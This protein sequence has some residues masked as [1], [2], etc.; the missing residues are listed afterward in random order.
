MNPTQQSIMKKFPNLTDY[1]DKCRVKSITI[2]DVV[3]QLNNYKV[4]SV[5]IE[6]EDTYRIMIEKAIM[7]E[8]QEE[9]NEDM[10]MKDE[11][12]IKLL[13]R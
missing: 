13:L 12:Y 8:K 3:G 7:I 6:F 2:L 4:F 5:G 11:P 9:N 1:I 10:E